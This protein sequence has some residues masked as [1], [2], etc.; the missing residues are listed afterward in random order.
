MTC[1]YPLTAFYPIEG[2]KP[3]FNPNLGYRDKVIK[4]PCGRCIGCRLQRS[5][6]WAIRCLHESKMHQESSFVTLTYDPRHL[7]T[8]ENLSVDE[9]KL[10]VKRLR[11]YYDKYYSKR[12]KFYMAGEYGE[13]FG[14]P[15]YHYCF[16]GIDFPDKKKWRKNHM[17]QQVYVSDTLSKIWGKGNC[18]IGSVTFESAAYVARYI[19]KKINGD[20][21]EEHYKHVTLKGELVNRTPE[22]NIMSRRPGIGKT[23]YDQFRDDIFPNDECIIKGCKMQPPSYYLKLYQID[24]IE[25]FEGVKLKRKQ[26]ALKN[27]I[28]DVQ[29]DVM[30]VV[31]EQKYKLLKRTLV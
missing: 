28:T 27:A 21:A 29:L 18:E 24:D 11:K 14:R 9:H 22:F 4:L 6:N 1:Y 10:F 17:N 30:R 3:V 23:F 15:H 7:P 26:N 8:D 25:G 20:M 19:C 31:K 12:F 13:N 2:K 16:F 5:K